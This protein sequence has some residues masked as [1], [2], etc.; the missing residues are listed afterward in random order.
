MRT[1]VRVWD[2]PTRVFHG[3]LVLCVIGSITTAQIGGVA[4][5]W[6]FRCGYAILSLLMFRLIWGIFGGR[7]SRF[8]AFTYTPK[9]T[10]AYVR[11]H[12]PKADP[13]VGHSP[14]GAL[15][16]FALLAVL[17]AQV[18]SG[19]TSDDQITFA[20]PLVHFVSSA[21]TGN[22]TWYHATVGKFILLGLMALHVGAIIFYLVVKR[23]NLIKP[24]FD[25]DK[26]IANATPGSTDTGA[27][28]SLALA[29]LIGCVLLVAWLV[30]LAV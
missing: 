7:W 24:M 26:D 11:G 20:G 10:M 14:A 1:K 4:M 22:A 13:S 15:S 2:L 23:E 6:H 3:A 27:T 21:W 9:A 28:R 30:K 19:L 16:V 8:N 5:E 25:G 29:I 18:F 12:H 17:L